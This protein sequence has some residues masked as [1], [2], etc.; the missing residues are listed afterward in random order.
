MYIDNIYFCVEC[1]YTYRLYTF[2]V[3]MYV[4]SSMCSFLT[5]LTSLFLLNYHWELRIGENNQL[6]N[7][8][9]VWSHIY[10]CNLYTYTIE[11]IKYI[12]NTCM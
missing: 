8:E 2:R 4:S 10:I 3:H 7:V 5:I 11:S 1:T 12:Y 6:R 9:N